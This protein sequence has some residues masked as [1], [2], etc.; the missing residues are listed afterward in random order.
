MKI[1]VLDGYTLNPGDNPWDEI[2]KLGELTVYDRTPEEEI[3]TRSEHADIILTNKVP[4]TEKHISALPKLQFISVLAT[5]YNTIDA[6]YAGKCGIPVSNVPDYG[7]HAVAEHTFALILE[8]SRQIRLHDT[9]VREGKWTNN[10]DWCVWETPQHSLSGK[11]L[12]I[13]GFGNTGKRTA[14][15]A[16]AFGMHV[17]VHTPRPKPVS[18]LPNVTFCSLHELAQCADIISLHCPLT[19][20]TYELIDRNFLQS[21]KDGAI[22]INTARGQLVDED[23]AAEALHQGK[24]YAMAT[25][26]AAQEPMPM[27]N[28]LLSA[29]NFLI[30]PHIAWATLTARRALMHSTAKNIASFIAGTPTNTVNTYGM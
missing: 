8:V 4:L 22:L 26:V 18:A 9:I 25:D 15:I 27:N 5:G 11:T 13:I 20:T 12:G 6:T 16:D 14:Q 7:T 1:V 2:A 3:I 23:A 17:M 24:L 10:P 29:P 19:E 30:T 28:P 21:M